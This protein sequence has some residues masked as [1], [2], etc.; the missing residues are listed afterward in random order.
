[1]LPDSSRTSFQN[2]SISWVLQPDHK[3]V[4]GL[5]KDMWVSPCNFFSPTLLRPRRVPVNVLKLHAGSVLQS[6]RREHSAYCLYCSFSCIWAQVSAVQPFSLRSSPPSHSAVCVLL[7]AAGRL[8]LSFRALSGPSVGCLSQGLQR[9]LSKVGTI[10]F[11]A[12][13][14]LPA[15]ELLPLHFSFSLH[16]SRPLVFGDFPASPQLSQSEILQ[17]CVIRRVG[18]A[19]EHNV[20]ELRNIVLWSP[21]LQ[22]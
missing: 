3:S 14:H 11:P 20:K 16:I 10:L 9:A 7:S 15:A 1:M 22:W 8:I 13:P 19:V 17:P 21:L 5:Q 18:N 12:V 2:C 6:R 4:G